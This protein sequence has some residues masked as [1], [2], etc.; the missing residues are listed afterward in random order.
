MS[1]T[2]KVGVADNRGMDVLLPLTVDGPQTAKQLGVSPYRLKNLVKFGLVRERGTQ[3][4]VDDEGN[5]RAG[6]PATVYAVTDKARAR[7]RRRIEAQ[8]KQ[9]GTTEPVEQVVA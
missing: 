4:H 5:L 7:A 2:K 1:T 3:K 6:R 8:R 9:N